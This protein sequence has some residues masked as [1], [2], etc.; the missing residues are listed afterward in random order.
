MRITVSHNKSRDEVVQAVD[1]S[2][3]D[4]FQGVNF[5]VKIADPQKS[6]NG[7]TMNFSLTAKMGLFSTPIKGT[8]EVTDREV[9][10]DA[11]L[12][13]LERLVPADKARDLIGTRVRGLLGSGGKTG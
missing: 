9:I 3:A 7:S 10:I 11:D 13:M 6:W 1:R 8:V 5:P 2:F 12:G 4:L